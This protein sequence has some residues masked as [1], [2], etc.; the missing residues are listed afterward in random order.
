MYVDLPTPS[1]PCFPRPQT[2]M[3]PPVVTKMECAPPAD[4]LATGSS[5]SLS[6]STRHGH[7][8]PLFHPA[9]AANVRSPK[10]SCPYLQS[11]H[12][13]TLPSEVMQMLC[14]PPATALTTRIPR[15]AAMRANGAPSRKVPRPSCPERPR[16]HANKRPARSTASVWLNFQTQKKQTRRGRR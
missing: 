1:A 14:A 8:T 5:M 13:Q 7:G 3:R 11:P 15:K 16:P 10:P 6:D 12:D 2:Y 9:A 4:M